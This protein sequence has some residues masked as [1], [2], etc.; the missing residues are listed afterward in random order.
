MDSSNVIALISAIAATAS[1][2]FAGCVWWIVKRTMI[3]QALLDVQKDYRSPQMQYAVRTLWQFYKEHGKEKL[4]EK[5]EEIR[6]EEQIWILSLDKQERVEAEQST[7]HYQRRLVSHFYQ[8][9]TALYVNKILP[10]D[11]VFSIWSEAD[12]RII[13]EILI[14]IE[15]K[16][17]EVLHIP[18]L[19]PLDENCSLLVLYK[20]SK[21]C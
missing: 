17:R 13:P 21:D 12:L 7:L 9:L 5:Y 11:I 20:D 19:G 16:L 18:P 1:T 10:K 2:L 14:P 8:H 6:D 15:N 4:V 3:H